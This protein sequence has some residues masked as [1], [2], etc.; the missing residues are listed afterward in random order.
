MGK[1]KW[2]AVRRLAPVAGA[3]RGPWYLPEGGC[4]APPGG[5]RRGGACGAWRGAARS[6]AGLCALPLSAKGTLGD[7]ARAGGEFSS[8]QRL[9]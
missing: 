5:A 3:E 2:L 6:G 7:G 8:R 1:C 9:P 4:G